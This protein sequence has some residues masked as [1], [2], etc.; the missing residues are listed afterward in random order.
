MKKRCCLILIVAMA[1]VLNGVGF[2]ACSF[3][4]VDAQF[5]ETVDEF[6]DLED[7][8]LLRYMETS[9]Y[10]E[11]VAALDSNDYFVEN[12]SAVYISAEYLEELDYNTK[13]NVFF[14]YSLSEIYEAFGD[15]GFIFTLGDNG[16]TVVRKF[17]DYD[18]TLDRIIRNVAIGSGVILICVTVSVVSAGAGAPAIGMI[19]AASAKTGTIMALSGAGLG[20]TASAVVTGIQ[21]GDVDEAIKAG[22]L[23][24][25]ESFKWGAISGV[26]TGGAKEI[27][28]LNHSTLNGLSM[29]E[30]A[31]IQ[32]ESKYPVDVISQFKS[33]EQYEICKNAG[34]KSQII[35]NR[36]ILIRDID[37]DYVDEL[38]RTNLTRMQNGLAA[39]D[40]N[41]GKAFEIHHL[42][43]KND[44]TLAILT[45]FEHRSKEMDKIWHVIKESEIDRGAFNKERAEIWKA[46]AKGYKV[47]GAV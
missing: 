13:T 42:M 40:P 35:N 46:I 7:A 1:L 3:A 5:S 10:R 36:N 41:T 29:N 17:I 47:G 22:L 33:Y 30:A 11:T 23:T 16:E 20:F 12:V 8:E 32:K 2:N 27:A 18:D 14:G 44:G 21:T 37:L 24:A 4:E 9:V 38:G 26:V 45:E 15:D 31:L 28:F 6:D 39:I 19:F 34:L 25:S 43:Q